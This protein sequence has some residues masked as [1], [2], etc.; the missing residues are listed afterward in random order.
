MDLFEKLERNMGPLGMYS[1]Q[2]EGYYVFPHIT[3]KL[4]SRMIFN[5]KEVVMWSINNY[6]GLGHRP[7][8]I[9]VDADATAEYGLCYPMGSRMMSGNTKQHEELEEGNSLNLSIKKL[10]YS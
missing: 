7:D 2:A 4:S 3:G 1:D 5:G 10:P 9:K 8:V 6:W